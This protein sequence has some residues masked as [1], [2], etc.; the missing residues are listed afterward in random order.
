MAR[1]SCPSTST[2]LNFQ[3][4]GSTGDIEISH[5]LFPEDVA[6]GMV[7]VGSVGVG[8]VHPLKMDNPTQ[9]AIAVFMVAPI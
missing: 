4:I 7:S 3:G 5:S 1:Y 8:F 6:D 2:Y 9:M